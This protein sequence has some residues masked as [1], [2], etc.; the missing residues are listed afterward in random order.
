[1]STGWT[2]AT[3]V[4]ANTTGFEKGMGRV[5]KKTT[6]AQ[7]AAKA[8]KVGLM[9]AGAALGAVTAIMKKSL[10]AYAVQERA[11][12]QLTAAL[13]STGHAA[14]LTADEIKKFA[15]QRQGVT[16][17]GD[18]ATIAASSVLLS[19]TNIRE[20]AFK[21]TMIAVQDL[22]ARMGTDLQ[23]ATVQLGKA[24]ND[25]VANLSA[26]SK[27]GIQFS[28]DQKK[29]IFSLVETG[30]LLGAQKLILGEL[31]TQF[32]GSATAA[33]QTYAGKMTQLSNKF[34]DLQESLGEKLVPELS[35]IVN[36]LSEAIDE[37]E[38]LGI[39]KTA[40]KMEKEPEMRKARL[41]DMT[42][43]DLKNWEELDKAQKKN[44]QHLKEQR[45]ATEKPGAI[46][47]ISPAHAAADWARRR[48]ERARLDEKIG[49]KERAIRLNAAS[50]ERIKKE[51]ARP[52]HE[53]GIEDRRL[54]WEEKEKARTDRLH[55]KAQ[56]LNAGRSAEARAE[57][58]ADREHIARL[59]AEQDRLREQIANQER[60]ESDRREDRDR[61][62]QLE[63]LMKEQ[64]DIAKQNLAA[65]EKLRAA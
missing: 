60:S 6:A 63:L 51:L 9:A 8:F 30:D 39:L 20:G 44:L 57:V 55:A 26:L 41:E 31:S 4:T 27:S 45:K 3:N 38:R 43:E 12:A 61:A 21:P 42:K 48:E 65:L 23:S 35:L 52:G 18:E 36:F 56:E 64:R 13:K 16:E 11:E 14:G 32:G 54:D 24:L 5:A 2:L 50:R 34:G 47:F 19:F 17:F 7:K 49:T 46:S 28:K 40:V 25:P 15:A 62:L 53:Q 29:M 59:E 58:V 37:A 22:A 10:E 33:A 1:M